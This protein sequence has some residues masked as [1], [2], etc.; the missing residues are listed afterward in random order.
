[1]CCCLDLWI[2]PNEFVIM[3]MSQRFK[4]GIPQGSCLGPSLFIF[5]I[6]DVFD[7]I[8]RN[9]N[10]MM[11]A[12]DCVL[13]KSDLCCDRILGCLQTGLDSYVTWGR[14]NNTVDSVLSGQ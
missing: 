9:I 14:E 3:T 2:G 12:D 1:M 5:Y 10:M 11:F 6:N 13:Y 8:D 7:C 4:C